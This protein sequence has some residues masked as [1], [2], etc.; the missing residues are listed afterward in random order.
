MSKASSLRL[1][2][3]W[4][5]FPLSVEI[6]GLDGKNFPRHSHSFDELVIVHEGAAEHSL[7]DNIFQLGKG[8]V[9][10]LRRGQSHAYLAPRNF[11]LTNIRFDS[12][13]LPEHRSR[14]AVMPGYHALF[15]RDCPRNDCVRLQLTPP[16][17]ARLGELARHI[18]Q[19]LA[20]MESGYASMAEAYFLEL[21]V[22]LIRLYQKS[23]KSD[24]RPRSDMAEILSY[25]HQNFAEALT[26]DCLATRAHMSTNTFLRAFR[27]ETGNSPIAHLARLR[28]MEGGRLLRHTELNI[29]EIA[30]AVG[31][32]DSNY[33]AKC[34]RKLVELSP[35]EYRKIYR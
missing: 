1:P 3:H 31:F 12:A 9:L 20:A 24:S 4:E 25:L 21:I 35:R 19:E 2:C 16:E 27:R 23:Q 26:L 6:G 10:L 28:V 29:T 33:F 30:H 14:L 15:T 13:R 17:L 32:S 34:F 18:Q 5:E 7:G 11:L 8:D 22:Y